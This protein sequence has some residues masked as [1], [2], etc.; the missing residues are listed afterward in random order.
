MKSRTLLSMS[1][2]SWSSSG[3]RRM[4]RSRTIIVSRKLELVTRSVP[5]CEAVMVGVLHTDD[6]W[7]CEPQQKVPSVREQYTGQR[8]KN[9]NCTAQFCDGWGWN[10]CV[11]SVTA[12]YPRR[13]VTGLPWQRRRNILWSICYS[14][15]RDGH[16]SETGRASTWPSSAHRPSHTPFA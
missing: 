4:S 8:G 7:T 13:F 2:R 16:A 9:R 1:E 6:V 12:G 10:G 5:T 15:S 3:L 14:L 11:G